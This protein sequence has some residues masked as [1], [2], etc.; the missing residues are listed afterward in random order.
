MFTSFA[1]LAVVSSTLLWVNQIGFVGLFLAF[2]ASIFL[3]FGWW[4]DVVRESSSQGFH[5]SLVVYGLKGGMLLFICSEVF[6]FLSFFWSFF[7]SSISPVVELGQ[8]WPPIGVVPFDPLNI[9][10]LNTLLLLSSGVS[11]T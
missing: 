11:V 7:H 1:I 10:L 8:Q 5:L 9:P 4:R 3:S 6:F 2:S